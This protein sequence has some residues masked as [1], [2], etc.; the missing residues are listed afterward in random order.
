MKKF[1][2]V[3]V[4]AMLLA[5]GLYQFAGLR[6]TLDGSGW[7]PRFVSTVPDYD[8]LEADRIKQR[9]SLAVPRNGD[10]STE[11]RS[12]PTPAIP[13]SLDPVAAPLTPPRRTADELERAESA[14]PTGPARISDRQAQTV[15]D[16]RG[17]WTDFRGP[18]RDGRYPGP[19]R[20][21]WPPGGLPVLWK[22]PIGLGYASFV[23]A[24][25]RAFTIEQRRGNEVVAAYDIDTG[26]E[27]WTSAWAG[28]FVEGMGG[29]GPRATPTY[30]DGRVYALGALGELRCLDAATGAVVWR[31]NILVDASATNLSWGMASAPLIVGRTVVVLPGGTRGRSVAAYDRLTGAPAWTALDDQQAYVSPMLVT[32]AGQ[33][34]IVVVSATRVVGL[35]PGDGTLLW[36]YPWA[37]DMGIN[38]AQPLVIGDNRLFVSAG[39]GQGAAVFEVT[40]TAGAFA[41]RT[42]WR[43]TRMK[44]KF[45]SSVLLDGF[46]YGLDESILTCLDAATGETKWKG[47]R[48]GYGQTLLAGS[49]LIVLTEEGELALVAATPD[50][51]IELARVPALEGKTW[52][53]PIVVDGRLLV[54]NLREMAAFD[55]RP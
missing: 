36:E 5:G 31:R 26:R 27:V 41:T 18:A 1:A 49:H 4:G 8:A 13:P 9:Q 35:A 39:Y 34:Q 25:G 7:L 55:I 2:F 32:L 46:I 23:A 22:Q 19:V 47:G 54:R 43:N 44:N 16:S 21:A 11:E 45:T 51:H 37:T 3:L 53:H 15:S 28:L 14:A 17:R 20:T 29:D 38:A 6:V 33:T 10:T 24:G 42:V 52:N 40:H 30:H 12:V 50:R 48:Y